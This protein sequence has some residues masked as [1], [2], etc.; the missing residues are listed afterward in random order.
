[1]AVSPDMVPNTHPSV[2]PGAVPCCASQARRI[3]R[4]RLP[5]SY[6]G[7]QGPLPSCFTEAQAQRGQVT[8]SRSSSKDEGR[9]EE[10]EMVTSS[11][12]TGWPA[13]DT[14]RP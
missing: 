13:P 9:R 8:W 4:K 10:R 14:G 6:A 11:R 2:Q 5:R 7:T 3:E 12:G 1:M